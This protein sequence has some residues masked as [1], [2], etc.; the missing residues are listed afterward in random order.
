[1]DGFTIGELAD[2]LTGGNQFALRGLLRDVGL[3]VNRYIED[4]TEA[5]PRA[6]VIDLAAL[7]A[8]DRIGRKCAEVL[9]CH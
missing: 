8:G 9:R 4:R 2:A 6:A 7:R 5:V 1:M 3:D